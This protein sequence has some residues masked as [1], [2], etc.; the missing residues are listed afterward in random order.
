[1]AES[2]FAT[3]K[4]TLA[5]IQAREVITEVIAGDSANVGK[6]EETLQDVDAKMKATIEAKFGKV[7]FE[8]F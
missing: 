1:M 8:K 5:S 3:V 4:S 6:I 7:E 2:D